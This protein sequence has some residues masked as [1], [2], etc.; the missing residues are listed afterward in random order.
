MLWE[1]LRKY[2][3][4]GEHGLWHRL[5]EWELEIDDSGI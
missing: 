1:G 3:M 2:V 4:D 5:R